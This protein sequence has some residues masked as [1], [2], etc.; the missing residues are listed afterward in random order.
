M[1]IKEA[2]ENKVIQIANDHRNDKDSGN[3]LIQEILDYGNNLDDQDKEIL[4]NFLLNLVDKQEE[5]LW[6]VALECLAKER[7]SMAADYLTK[8]IRKSQRNDQWIYFVIFTISKIGRKEDLALISQYL[9]E[10]LFKKNIYQWLQVVGSVIRTDAMLG[11]ELYSKFLSKKVEFDK[12]KGYIP[13]IIYNLQD[14]Q[15]ALFATLIRNLKEN[16]GDNYFILAELL[17]EYLEKP[18]VVKKYSKSIVN[19]SISI[20]KNALN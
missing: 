10:Y 11:I 17:I 20:I 15:S 13:S 18:W 5:S 4:R 2:I 3:L 14:I 7:N 9:D 8:L 1:N 6:A 12:L 19:D 16:G